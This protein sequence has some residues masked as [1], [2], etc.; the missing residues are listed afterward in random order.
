MS[1]NKKIKL[2]DYET[3]DSE[4][5]DKDKYISENDGYE[6]LH[7]DTGDYV[8]VKVDED[9]T[10]TQNSYRSFH[11]I[12]EYV[13]IEKN[14]SENKKIVI[15]L[16]QEQIKNICANNDKNILLEVPSMK[17][18]QGRSASFTA[19]DKPLSLLAKTGIRYSLG[20]IPMAS[21]VHTIPIITT[22]DSNSSENPSKLSSISSGS[23][24][25][26]DNVI[27]DVPRKHSLTILPERKN[28]DSSSYSYA[29]PSSLRAVR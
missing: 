6:R 28:S 5:E 7:D 13:E 23:K 29:S 19:I 27:Y 16:S 24:F 3:D 17:K 26:S 12:D 25:Q 9:I 21:I 10:Y 14:E 20:K 15:S 22:S 8:E 4:Y 18:K 11:D 2:K 1:T